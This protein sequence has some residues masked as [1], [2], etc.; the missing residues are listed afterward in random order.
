M[1]C[2]KPPSCAAEHAAFAIPCDSSTVA[3]GKQFPGVRATCGSSRP[4]HPCLKF[5]PCLTANLIYP[6]HGP[7]TEAY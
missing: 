6:G 2:F 1:I 4:D 3:R 5:I 7:S